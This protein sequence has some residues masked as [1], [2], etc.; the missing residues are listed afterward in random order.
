MT[1][2]WIL[3][4][5]AAAIVLVAWPARAETTFPDAPFG[6]IVREDRR[7]I[8]PGIE[9]LHRV[10]DDPMSIHV[11]T[12]GLEESGVRI[13]T[14]LGQ[15]SVNG[16]ETVR[17]MAQ[18]HDALIGINGDYWTYGGIPL[19]LTVVNGEIVI[20][21]KHRT[22]FGVT[23]DGVPVIDTFTDEWSWQAEVIAPN[24][25]RM[26]IR[27]LN[28]DCNPGWLCLYTD[29]WGRPSRG[30]TVS[31]V[32]EVVLN[33]EGR[34]L[35]V[36]TD[37]PGVEI[38][39]GGFV[40]TGRD[41]AGEWLAD[42]FETGDFAVLDLKS[43]RPW[44]EL[45]TAIGAGPRIL[46]DGEIFQDP[47]ALHPEGEEFTLEWKEMHY[48][49]RQPRSAIGITEDK[50]TI[51]LIAV[52]GRQ[53]EHSIGIYQHQIARL[54]REFG[55]SDAM[56]LDSGGSTTLVIEGE[57][58]NKPSDKAN[59]DGTGGVERPVANALIFFV[60]GNGG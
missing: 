13:E 16:L 47:I 45:R 32:T 20:A 7:T 52:D 33:M 12:V 50:S 56:D 57:V 38:P 30:N 25:D 29:K 37:L 51:I 43:T 2:R 26:W 18:R 28:S 39:G 53:P 31:P 60:D 17:S 48:L 34:V 23:Y 41:E 3:S 27:L 40:L 58:V 59:A 1:A 8:A 24:H 44:Q 49:K 6:D 36:R 11:V 4:A 19:N 55:A 22:A 54:F 9:Y 21:P 42:H 10:T 15:D 14:V 35:D 46:S 5:I